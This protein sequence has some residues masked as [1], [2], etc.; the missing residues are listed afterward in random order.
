MRKPGGFDLFRC[1]HRFGLTSFFSGQPRQ[2]SDAGGYEGPP[3][4]EEETRRA[5]KAPM[6]SLVC[7][8]EIFQ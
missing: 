5:G 6:Q 3:E 1:L 2:I 8:K 4:E 7:A